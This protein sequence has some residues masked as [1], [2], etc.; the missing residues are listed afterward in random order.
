MHQHLER[1]GDRAGTPLAKTISVSSVRSVVKVPHM[2]QD[3]SLTRRAF[4]EKAA[5]ITAIGFAAPHLATGAQPAARPK[6]GPNSRI[7]VE[8]RL[9]PGHGTAHY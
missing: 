1:A 3:N 6:P 2:N 4:L 7:H 8:R 9:D 5:T